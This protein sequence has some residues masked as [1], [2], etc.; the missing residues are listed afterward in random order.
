MITYSE[1]LSSSSVSKIPNRDVNIENYDNLFTSERLAKLT[2][3]NLIREVI[4]EH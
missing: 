3:D 1:R 2:N 4:I